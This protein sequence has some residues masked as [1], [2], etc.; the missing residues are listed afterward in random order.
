VNEHVA[1]PGSLDLN[2]AHSLG[3]GREGM[4]AFIPVLCPIDIDQAHVSLVAVA[5][6]SA[7]CA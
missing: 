3:G 5:Q 6:S 7:I 2:P 1:S 4:A